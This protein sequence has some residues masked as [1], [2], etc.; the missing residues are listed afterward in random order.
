M[1]SECVTYSSTNI[2]GKLD[3][4]PTPEFSDKLSFIENRQRGSSRVITEIKNR[5]C[6]MYQ[7]CE[8]MQ[9]SVKSTNLRVNKMSAAMKKNEDTDERIK[10]LEDQI[11]IL[12][13]FMKKFIDE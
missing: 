7:L 8:K 10:E 5:T 12:T 11:M 9:E 2:I 6:D 3:N 13:Q 1:N 4:K